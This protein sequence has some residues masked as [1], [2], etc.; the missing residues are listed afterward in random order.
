MFLQGKNTFIR[1]KVIGKKLNCGSG[2]GMEVPVNYRFHGHGKLIR[3]F[4]KRINAI[5]NKLESK[6]VKC[7]KQSDTVT[8]AL[9]RYS[10]QRAKIYR[11]A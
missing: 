3:W 2:Y 9:R 11:K 6:V 4:I 8:Q 1:A 10:S 7:L 5:K